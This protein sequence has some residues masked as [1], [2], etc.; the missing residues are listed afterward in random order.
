VKL[1][2]GAGHVGVQE[3]AESDQGADAGWIC[4]VNCH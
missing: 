2:A 4:Q 1:V 3:E